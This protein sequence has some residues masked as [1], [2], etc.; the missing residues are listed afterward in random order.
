LAPNILRPSKTKKPTRCNTP[1]RSTTSAYS[2]TNPPAGPGCS[3]SSHPTSF[4][5]KGPNGNCNRS[6]FRERDAIRQWVKPVACPKMADAAKDPRIA[7]EGLVIGAAPGHPI[8]GNASASFLGSL[9]VFGGRGGPKVGFGTTSDAGK[10]RKVT[11]SRR[12][13]PD[14]ILPV[15]RIGGEAISSAWTLLGLRMWVPTPIKRMAL[16]RCLP[17]TTPE[18]HRPEKHRSTARSPW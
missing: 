2:S 9:Q 12:P 17:A 14:A 15:G 13:T 3:S 8:V 1:R 18:H 4:D 5:C 11:L 6:R 10:C 7:A 16:V